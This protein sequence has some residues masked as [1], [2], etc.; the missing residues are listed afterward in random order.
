MMHT[1]ILDVGYGNLQSLFR[2]FSTF[3]SVSFLHSPNDYL[4]NP[5]QSSLIVLPGVGS[6]SS[7]SR[8]LECQGF[9]SFISSVV[10]KPDVLIIGIC[11]GMQLL[12]TTGYEDG[13]S[14]GLN[15]IPGEVVPVSTTDEM[16]MGWQPLTSISPLLKQMSPFTVFDPFFYFA[17]S[18]K[19][20]VTDP[21]SCIALSDY[22]H[23]PS[24]VF[25]DNVLGLQFHP[26]LSQR[27]GHLLI[28]SFIEYYF[29]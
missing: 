28:A 23:Y 5:A 7:A 4:P 1:Y 26:E 22:L 29:K 9:H 15:V 27:S 21:S 17:H 16:V 6:F 14:P 25:R 12:A 13:V 18:Y 10:G 24:I 8:S 20:T 19:F 3:G 11:L 2:F